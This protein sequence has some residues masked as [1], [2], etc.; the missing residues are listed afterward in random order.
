MAVGA[1]FND[2]LY[3]ILRKQYISGQI[4]EEERQRML[5]EPY[6][7]TP[8][9]FRCLIYLVNHKEGAEPSK[10][11]DSLHIL[12]Q[13][14]TGIAD[15]LEQEGYITRHQH[16]NDRRRILLVI[17]PEGDAMARK[18][19]KVFRD[20]HN[21]ITEN[22]TEEEIQTYIDLRERMH[23]ARDQAISD[24]LTARNTEE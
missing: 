3:G 5:F 6:G 11:A 7:E 20:Y 8:A 13:T 16:P 10:M 4:K 22:F 19:G 18:L 14:V 24:I 21:R 2:S 12:R 15:H 1:A 9:S 17:T 23:K